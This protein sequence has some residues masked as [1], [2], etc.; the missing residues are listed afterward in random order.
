MEKIMLDK[1]GFPVVKGR[2]VN[3]ILSNINLNNN[4]AVPA[5]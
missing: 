3:A 2:R 5:A 1:I 4:R